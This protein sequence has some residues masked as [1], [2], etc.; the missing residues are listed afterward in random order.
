MSRPF[1]KFIFDFQVVAKCPEGH[2][3]SLR[4]D[5]HQFV[6]CIEPVD[7][8]A[9]MRFNAVN[10]TAFQSPAP[11]QFENFIVAPHDT[12]PNP[13]G[14]IGF[15]RFGEKPFP[16]IP[17]FIIDRTDRRYGFQKVSDLN[18]FIH[19][20]IAFVHI[21]QNMFRSKGTFFNQIPE[22]KNILDP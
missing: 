13:A 12:S 17:V 16:V 21:A 2:A 14:F 20:G 7:Q 22:F 4:S 1:H 10:N 6:L 11:E 3:E 9:D 5:G 15:Q 19:V 18:P 8:P